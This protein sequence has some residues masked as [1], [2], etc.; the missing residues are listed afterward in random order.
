MLNICK[1]CGFIFESIYTR[2]LSDMDGAS[3]VLLEGNTESCTNCG[4]RVETGN[5]AVEVRQGVTHIISSDWATEQNLRLIIEIFER[6]ARREITAKEA[7][8]EA[9]KISPDA[10][11]KVREWVNTGAAAIAAASAVLGAYLA[12]KSET[13]TN[14]TNKFEI[15]VH[16]GDSI[17]NDGADIERIV[18][19]VLR[20]RIQDQK[21]LAE[22]PKSLPKPP[23]SKSSPTSGNRKMRKAQDAKERRAKKRR[24]KQRRTDPTRR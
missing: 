15:S 2:G 11:K 13:T 18:E 23:E 14:I 19:R 4:A 9:A 8:K 10:G 17:L 22:K 20:E 6:Y 16:V 24:L 5:G 21:K 1:N 7:E 3:N 12:Y